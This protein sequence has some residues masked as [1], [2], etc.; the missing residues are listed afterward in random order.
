MHVV[1]LPFLPFLMLAVTQP[2]SPPSDPQAA[3]AVL[4]KV[5]LLPDVQQATSVEL[6]GAFSLADGGRGAHYRAPRIGVLR[7]QATGDAAA[8]ARAQWHDLA[9]HVGTGKVVGFGSRYEMLDGKRVWQVQRADDQATPVV[10]AWSSGFGVQVLDH[11]D[12][13]AS[14]ELALLPRCTPVDLGRD[15]HTAAYPRSVVFTATNCA[16]GDADLRYVFH[17]ATS[18]GERF[19]SPPV[20]PGK[21]LTTWETPMVLDV[22]ERIDWSVHVIGAKVRRAPLAEATFTVPAA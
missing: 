6:H 10:G 18:D 17:V 8:A 21:G 9:K 12:Y 14:R 20:A 5:V 22:G 7:L 2:G 13:G 11:V 19:A 4:D 15:R 1:A 16:A 3:Y